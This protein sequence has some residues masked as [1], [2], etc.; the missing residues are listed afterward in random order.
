M[1]Y[2]KQT[3]FIQRDSITK[4]R[5]NSVTSYIR[6]VLKN[7]RVLECSEGYYFFTREGKWKTHSSD[8]RVTLSER[9]QIKDCFDKWIAITSIQKVNDM[10]KKTL[11]YL[12]SEKF[13]NFYINSFITEYGLNLKI[14][15][16]NSEE[17]ISMR[18]HSSETILSI[19]NTL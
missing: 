17:L 6:I 2:N 5:K 14:Q 4:F 3:G 15:I 10:N 1:S 16:G 18:V 7:E 11:I 9:D 12:E 8:E 13:H 19:K